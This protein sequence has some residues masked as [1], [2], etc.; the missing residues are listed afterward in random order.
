MHPDIRD[1]ALQNPTNSHQ[2]RQ[3]LIPT[4]YYYCK[5]S[6]F[7]ILNYKFYECII[8]P[9]FLLGSEKEIKRKQ[10]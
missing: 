3:L 4:V 7:K 5:I 1:H 6:G 10:D 2:K 9:Y 8:E